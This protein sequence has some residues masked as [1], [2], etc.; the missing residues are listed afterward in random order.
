MPIQITNGISKYLGL[1][2]QVGKIQKSSVQV[3]YR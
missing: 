2:T 1:P 3:Y